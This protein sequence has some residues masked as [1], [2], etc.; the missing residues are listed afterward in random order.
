MVGRGALCVSLLMSSCVIAGIVVL[1]L[2]AKNLRPQ[3]ASSRGATAP[4]IQSVLKRFGAE[5][6]RF[7][8]M[9]ERQGYSG[10]DMQ[11]ITGSDGKLYLM[12][13]DMSDEMLKKYLRYLQTINARIKRI[14]QF[15]KPQDS[16][17]PFLVPF[18]QSKLSHVN[19]N[20]DKGGDA[21]AW[22]DGVYWDWVF[23]SLPALPDT[24][25]TVVHFSLHEL[26]HVISKSHNHDFLFFYTFKNLISR[27]VECKAFDPK[28]LD[29]AYFNIKGVGACDTGMA[30]ATAENWDALMNDIRN[31]GI[32]FGCPAGY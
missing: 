18:V 12:Q 27:A 28:K 15:M 3:G 19:M 22:T 21:A 16:Y 6:Q 7:L 23:I 9:F 8:T 20:P 14:F 29:P 11:A 30:V 5:G 25:E 10:S 13:R 24:M 32:R 2:Q 31:F 17:R 1:I 4:P 26:S